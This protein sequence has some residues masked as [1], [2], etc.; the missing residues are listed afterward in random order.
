MP[1]TKYGAAVLQ[2]Y[3]DDLYSRA[4]WVIFSTAFPYELITF[5]LA[6]LFL[7]GADLLKRAECESINPTGRSLNCLSSELPSVST[8]SIRRR[9]C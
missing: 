3:A 6:F 2:K 7:C 4:R 5:V 8:P 9:S 1:E